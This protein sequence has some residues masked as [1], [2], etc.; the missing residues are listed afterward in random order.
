MKNRNVLLVIFIASL[1]LLSCS[2]K[3]DE[4]T[5]PTNKDP[6][7]E[8]RNFN[9]I[10]VEGG[11][12]IMGDKKA[13]ERY[14]TYT[15]HKVK[16]NDFYISDIEVT[17]NLYKR[18]MQI[19]PTFYEEDMGENRPVGN[20]SWYEAVE[21]C[22]RLSINDG[23]EPCYIMKD[24]N[25]ECNF[26]AN[27]YRLPTE[28]EWEYAARGGKYTHG[29]KFSGCNSDQYDDYVWSSSITENLENVATKLPNELNIYDMSG[30][31]SEMCWDWYDENYYAKSKYDNPRGPEK[32]SEISDN[33]GCKVNRG[34]N[35]DKGWDEFTV[36][37][38]GLTRADVK[39]PLVGFRICRKKIE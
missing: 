12:F 10:D 36:F 15:P 27:G 20:I 14:G 5:L 4:K 13:N 16:V 11:E 28:A 37:H 39:W 18:I 7:V 30:N 35:F 33:I 29:Y 25:V 1:I 21:F 17:Q 8:I 2:K 22:N 24:K 3:D 9:M 31:V 6:L 23:F 38:R 19:N 26:N 32:S 34:G